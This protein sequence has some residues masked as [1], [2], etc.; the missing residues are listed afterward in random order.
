MLYH[1]RRIGN[2]AASEHSASLM[3]CVVILQSHFIVE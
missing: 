2:P 3:W 1:L